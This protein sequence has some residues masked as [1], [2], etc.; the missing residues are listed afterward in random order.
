MVR[1]ADDMKVSHKNEKEVTKFMDYM[2]VIYGDNITVAKV[3]R[4][5]SVRM[6]L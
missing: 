6:D 1:H 4:N 3:K 5:T 2:T